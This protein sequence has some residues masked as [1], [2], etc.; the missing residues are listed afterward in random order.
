MTDYQYLL[1]ISIEAAIKAGE[2]TLDFFGKKISI[3]TKKDN[4]PLTKADLGS[5]K[6]INEILLQSGIPIL[7]E[8]NKII[9]YNVRKKW[10]LYW[11]VDPLDGTKEFIQNSPEYTVNIALIENN[12]PIMGVIYVPAKQILYYGS[13]KNGAFKV[14]AN[15]S[16]NYDLLLKHSIPLP[17]HPGLNNTV[18]IIASKSHMSEETI[19]F[20][21]KIK[22][23]QLEIDLTSIGSSLKFCLMAE[24]L[25]DIY[26][27][28]GRTMEWDT[29]AGQ[30]IAESA[31]C[32]LV[33]VND[34]KKMI[35][36][37]EELNNPSFIAYNEKYSELIK[38]IIL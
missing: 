33:N 12:I 13:L 4:S 25:S 26:P 1:K 14:I 19:G 9:P 17:I 16:L 30:V 22:K 21:D 3:K 2:R 32:R 23:N 31:N 37:K 11:L 10:N 6:I 24:G 28:Y 27:R 36:N 20:I 8:E 29:A 34:G 35:Y 7:S 5:N 15:S 18:T 38:N